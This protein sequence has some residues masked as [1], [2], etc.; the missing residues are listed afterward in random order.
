MKYL[1]DIDLHKIYPAIQLRLS[2]KENVLCKM[3]TVYL[4]PRV[5]LKEDKSVCHWST[6]T[7][8]IHWVMKSENGRNDRICQTGK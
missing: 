5:S 4:D 1:S 8:G 3:D 7:G 6:T 2:L